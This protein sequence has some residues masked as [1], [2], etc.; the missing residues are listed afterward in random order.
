MEIR[1]VQKT[2]GSSYVITLPKEW[3]EAG[4]VKKN[5]PLGVVTQPDGTLL[6][7]RDI[8]EELIVR[9]KKINVTPIS[10]PDYLFRILVS[11]YISGYTVLTLSCKDRFQPF[12]RMRVREFTGMAIGPQVIEE[13]ENSIVLKDLL[14]PGEMP[15]ENTLK[16]MFVIVR[17]MHEDAITALEQNDGALG[18]DVIQ[19]D[20]DVD[21][22]HWLVARQANMILANA[23]LARR[24]GVTPS[25]VLHYYTISRIIERVGDHAVRICEHVDKIRSKEFDR[26]ILPDLRKISKHSVRIFDKSLASF[27]AADLKESNNNIEEVENLEEECEEVSGLVLENETAIAVSLRNI[28]E[29]IRRSGEY[30]GDISETVMNYLVLLDED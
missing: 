6:I 29:S 27:F 22:L 30:A 1:K 9:E 24:M 3:I 2:G 17:T 4:N 16:R 12:V 13:T 15:F 26:G 25:L 21:R 19:R 14:N 18:S 8:R 23:A 28:A 10:D 7:T 20:N 5:D 11:S